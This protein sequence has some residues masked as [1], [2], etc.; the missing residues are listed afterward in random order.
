MTQFLIS[1]EKPEG[2]KLED[3]LGAIRKDIILRA[4]K[5]L[6]DDRPEA[7]QVLEN[8]IKILQLLSESINIAEDSTCLLDKNFGR[9]E[10]GKPRIGT[11]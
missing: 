10:P 1:E 4:T 7:R 11:V 5:I 8:S 3:I 6:D 9:H 2:F